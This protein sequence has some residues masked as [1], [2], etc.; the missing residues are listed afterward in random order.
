MPAA[1]F[2]DVTH[3]TLWVSVGLLDDTD[4]SVCHVQSED[5]Y[6]GIDAHAASEDSDAS[7]ASCLS[8][9]TLKQLE[10]IHLGLH[11]E[12][13]GGDTRRRGEAPVFSESDDQVGTTNHYQNRW[14]WAYRAAQ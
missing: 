7:R 2:G 4:T 10:T 11:T 9:G 1:Y 5:L 14:L 12:A 6:E 3:F 8:A 13:G